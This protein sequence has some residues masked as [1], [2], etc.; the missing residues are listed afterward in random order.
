MAKKDRHIPQ[1]ASE[2]TAE[3][4]DQHMPFKARVTAVELETIGEG[5]GFMGELYRC[6]LTWEGG[7]GTEPATVITKVPSTIESNRGVGEGLMVYEREI[8]CYQTMADNMGIPMPRHYYSDMDP[9]PAP[10]AQNIVFFLFERLSP[11][12]LARLMTG[13][14]KMAGKNPR[15]YIL[16]MEDIADARPPA[17]VEGG[18]LD[19]AL[20]SLQIL[21]RFHAHHWG[22]ANV[23]DEHA[24]IFSCAQLPRI[25]QA[26]Y[27]RC[28]DEFVE[29]FGSV[30]GP[31]MVALMDKVQDDLPSYLSPLGQEPSTLLHG[32]YRLDNVLFRPTGDVV[33]LDYQLL[34]YGRPGW[35]VAYFITT[36]L[37][38]DHR[39]EESQMLHVYHDA[40]VQA[41]V[42]NY[43]FDQLAADCEATKLLLAHRMVGS[44]NDMLQTEMA[45]QEDS[46]L[47]L[48]VGRVFGWL[49]PA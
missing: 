10:W 6:A 7:D 4:F 32:D 48:I 20:V 43:S 9:D 31:D 16:V 8:D 2:L 37:T 30:V 45:G 21:A 25:W 29:Q 11:K 24:R 42:T 33:V 36:A 1:V 44:G 39:H 12:A 17:Q 40:L 14:V 27:L 49:T 35:D 38:P 13:F 23:M 28:R 5:I 3:W 41:G 15:R 26:G 46:F 34:A 19:D 47:D 22:K 18:T